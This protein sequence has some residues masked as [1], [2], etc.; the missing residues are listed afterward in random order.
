M[1]ER[2][3]PIHEQQAGGGGGLGSIFA[4][5]EAPLA[6]VASGPYREQLPVGNLT[7]G[8]IRARFRDRFDIDARSQA[9]VDGREVD[10]RTVIRAGQRLTF[11]RKSGEK[12]AAK[13]A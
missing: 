2:T 13:P 1:N 9:F 12:G 8:E 7:V 6:T 10:D 5:D 4:A 3:R 11:L